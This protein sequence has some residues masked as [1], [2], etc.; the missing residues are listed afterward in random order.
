MPD[1][2]ITTS[3]LKSF[4]SCPLEA[5]YQEQGIQRPERPGSPLSRGSF[6]HELLDKGHADMPLDNMFDE[7]VQLYKSYEQLYE[8]YLFNWRNADWHRLKSEF[9]LSRRLND[10]TLYQG[11]VDELVLIGNEVWLVDHKTHKQLPTTEFRLLDIQSDAYIWLLTPWLKRHH[12]LDGKSDLRFG[13]FVWDYLIMDKIKTPTLVQNGTRFKRLRGDSLP[14]TDFTT[15]RRV[16]LEE[17]CATLVTEDRVEWTDKLDQDEQ[18]FI[19]DTLR[20]LATQPCDAFVRHFVPFS[21]EQHARQVKFIKKAVKSFLDYDFTDRP[22]MRNPLLCGNSY[23]CGHDKL[24]LA[25]LVT[26]S[27]ESAM[28]QYEQRDPLARYKEEEQKA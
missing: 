11:K 8:A 1:R 20:Q 14:F 23:L 17:N 2:I 19:E 26:G 15:L 22:I 13:G 4:L 24:A 16:L 3:L 28:N 27:D 7:E 21:A 6:I 9:K 12:L 10:H 25:E 5:Y 18:H